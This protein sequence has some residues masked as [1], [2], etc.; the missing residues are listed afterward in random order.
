MDV[1]SH[2][3]KMHFNRFEIYNSS[4][5]FGSICGCA[6]DLL[7]L[8][9]TLKII[10]PPFFSALI[11]MAKGGADSLQRRREPPKDD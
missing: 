10:N 1:V 3:L 5:E 9:K 6:P 2:S 7:F 11:I 8:A 4:E